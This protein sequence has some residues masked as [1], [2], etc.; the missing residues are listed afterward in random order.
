MKIKII[1]LQ[2]ICCLW[3][4]NSEDKAKKHLSHPKKQNIHHGLSQQEILLQL[5]VVKLLAL[6]LQGNVE[7]FVTL[8]LVPHTRCFSGLWSKW[9][10][11]VLLF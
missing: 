5:S 7:F 9:L 4:C 8:Q 11:A 2:N 10:A 3:T 1:L 6:L